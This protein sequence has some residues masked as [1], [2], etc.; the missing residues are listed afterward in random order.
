MRISDLDAGV[1]F[2][3]FLLRSSETQPR[4]SGGTLQSE[5]QEIIHPVVMLALVKALYSTALACPAPARASEYCK[6]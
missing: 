5:R 2:R 1:A 6:F 3:I 4:I